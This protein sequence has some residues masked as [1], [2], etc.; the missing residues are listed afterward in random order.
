MTR[1]RVVATVLILFMVWGSWS[2][3]MAEPI[4]YT[5]E[6]VASGTAG[7]ESFTDEPVVFAGVTDTSGFGCPTGYAPGALL[8]RA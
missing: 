6:F 1:R 8:A 4:L 5:I 3:A 7:G 2:T